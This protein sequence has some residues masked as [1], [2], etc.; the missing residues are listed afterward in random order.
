MERSSERKQQG[1]RRSG[2]SNLHQPPHPQVSVAKGRSG[3]DTLPE[4]RPWASLSV[5]GLQQALENSQVFL[6]PIE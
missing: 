2:S 5:Q 1:S 4:Q 3:Q 6:Y